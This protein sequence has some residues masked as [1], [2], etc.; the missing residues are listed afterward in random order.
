[1]CLSSQQRLPTVPCGDADSIRGAHTKVSVTLTDLSSEEQASACVCGHQCFIQDLD[2]V[3]STLSA[4]YRNR[5][6]SAR[7]LEVT[8]V[9]PQL[10][11][12]DRKKINRKKRLAPP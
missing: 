7:S 3:A 9:H 5:T 11:P 6:L 12:L 4:G 10:P 1:M 2:T 8:G